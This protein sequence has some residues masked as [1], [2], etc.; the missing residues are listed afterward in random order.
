[1]PDTLQVVEDDLV[2]ARQADRSLGSQDFSRFVAN[3]NIV[4]YFLTFLSLG[5]AER[6]YPLI[7]LLEGG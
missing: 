6:C 4:H 2:A 3:M 5:F 7:F 1:M